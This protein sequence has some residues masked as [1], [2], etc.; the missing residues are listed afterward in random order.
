M[1]SD[2]IKNILRELK[3]IRIDVEFI[4]DNMV[5]SDMVLTCEEKNRLDES[6]EEFKKGDFISLIF[7]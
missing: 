2:E 6:I 5:D 7:N 4:K 3:M 1:E